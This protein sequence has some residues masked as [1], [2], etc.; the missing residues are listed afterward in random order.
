MFGEHFRMEELTFLTWLDISDY[1]FWS[2]FLLVTISLINFMSGTK[3]V[4]VRW[5]RSSFWAPPHT[6]WE[7]T[8]ETGSASL[9]L[10][11]VTGT[12]LLPG[13]EA[14]IQT[15]P[16]P[17][18]SMQTSHL[19]GLFPVNPLIY[20]HPHSNSP[21]CC[22]SCFPCQDLDAAHPISDLCP[23]VLEVGHCL[24]LCPPE[25]FLL[26]S[27]SVHWLKTTR[28]GVILSL[29]LSL[30]LSLCLPPGPAV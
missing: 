16:P 22:W 6:R 29:S 1:Y 30:S 20:F 2:Y 28:T 27:Q 25:L 8:S 9:K 19:A 5:L 24:R 11:Q 10:T 4:L 21:T 26:P 17:P 7:S 23:P 3:S 15:N 18:S 14:H 12:S 13:Y